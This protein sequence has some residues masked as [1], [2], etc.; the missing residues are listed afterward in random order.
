MAHENLNG[1]CPN[2][3]GLKFRGPSRLGIQAIVP[4]LVSG[5][6][7]SNQ[8]IYD[9]T[10]AVVGP[11]LWNVLPPYLTTTPSASVFKKQLTTYLRGL[12]DEPPVTGYTRR[13]RNTLPEV[14]RLVGS[15][16]Q[17]V[18]ARSMT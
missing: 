14:T 2:E 4:S 11:Q 12:V 16:R 10:F 3:V 13:H 6:N 9:R 5:S 8:T 7:M 18:V 1:L 15:V 17:E